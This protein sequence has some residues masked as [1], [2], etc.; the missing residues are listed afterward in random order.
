MEAIL[1]SNLKPK[2]IKALFVGNVLGDFSEGQGMVQSF[3][4]DDIGCKKH[5]CDPVRGSLRFWNNGDS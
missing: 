3:A 4:A 1:S 2:D 5:P